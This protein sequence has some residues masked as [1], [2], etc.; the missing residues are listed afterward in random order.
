MGSGRVSESARS[1]VSTRARGLCEYC[2]GNSTVSCGDFTVD[3]IIPVS[4]GS[5]DDDSNLALACHGCNARKHSA[6]HADD[7]LTG[8]RT[9]LFHPRLQSWNDHFTWSDQGL[10]V[11]PKTPVGRATV[12]R[13][14]LNRP[15]AVRHRRALILL[16]SHPPW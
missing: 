2:R 11:V 16:G 9:P 4:A 8:K 6:T 13:L 5:S 10:E 12:Q 7:P 3:H 14:D 1:A 15:G